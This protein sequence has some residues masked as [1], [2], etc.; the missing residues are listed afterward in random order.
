MREEAIRRLENQLD[1]WDDRIHQLEN[2]LER[3][4]P[5][6]RSR[7]FRDIQ[8]LKERRDAVKNRINLLKI[9]RAE[10]WEEEDLQAGILRVFDDIGIRVNRLVS[11]VSEAH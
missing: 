4:G 3:F 5:R 6:T 11:R 2:E 1:G 8:E 10:S 9:R 7:Y